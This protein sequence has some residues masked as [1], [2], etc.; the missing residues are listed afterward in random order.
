MRNTIKCSLAAAMLALGAFQ[1]N[2]LQI[3]DL[4]WH[5]VLLQ[6]SGGQKSD[7]GTFDISPPYNPATHNLLSAEVFFYYT[8]DGLDGDEY[9]KIRLDNGLG[10]WNVLLTEEV[11]FLDNSSETLGGAAFASLAADGSLDYKVTATQGDFWFLKAILVADIGEK[12]NVPDGGATLALLGLG[13][14][15]L[16]ALHRRR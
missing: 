6:A 11:G 4:N 2:A 10:G 14:L 1:A 16:G 3:N 15:G 5:G 12:A 7:E 8:D 13:V 9:V